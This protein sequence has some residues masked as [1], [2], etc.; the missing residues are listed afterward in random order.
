LAPPRTPARP[1]YDQFGRVVEVAASDPA[2]RTSRGVGPGSPLRQLRAVYGS[3][4]H[5]RITRL[6]SYFEVDRRI[7]PTL[8]RTSFVGRTRLADVFTVT[9][10][11]VH[12]ISL[13]VSRPSAGGLVVAI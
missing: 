2:R 5:S 9:V 3:R 11:S 10:R 13:R 8:Y 6:W 7:G 4:L 12:E 1:A